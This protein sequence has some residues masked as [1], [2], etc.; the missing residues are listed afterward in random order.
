MNGTYEIIISNK[1]LEYRLVLDHKIT[2]IKGQSGSGKT[3]LINLIARNQGQEDK[4]ALRIYNPRA[5]GLAVFTGATDWD[6]ELSRLNNTVVLIDE[7]VDYV[8]SKGFQ[9]AVA[10]ADCYF[11]ICSRSG[12]FNNM[13]YSI[14]SIYELKSAKNGERSTLTQMY[15]LY[16]VVASEI[17]ADVV[18]CEDTNSGHEFYSVMLESDVISACGNGNVVNTIRNNLA[19]NMTVIVDGAAYG[20][21]VEQTLRLL[22][23]IKNG[24]LLAPESFEFLLLSTEMFRKFAE[25]QISN[26]SEFCD[27]KKYITW[28][29]YYTDLLKELTQ[30]KYSFAYSKSKLNRQLMNDSIIEEVREILTRYGVDKNYR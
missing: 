4:S 15:R 26:T 12:Q 2:I 30:E 22:H 29:R 21:F 24:K 7:S 25:E 19:D 20:G 1:R 9:M 11:V 23:T 8:Y 27:C 18:I 28:E 3:S 5:V 10:D 6:L 17:D 14:S 16:E 13:P